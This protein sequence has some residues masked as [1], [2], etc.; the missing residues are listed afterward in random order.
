MSQWRIPRATTAER[1]TITPA[2]G[3]VIYDTDLDQL[4]L[5]DGATV[6]GFP[7]PA[8]GIPVTIAEGG[9]GQITAQAAIDALSAVSGATNEHVLTK[10][11]ATGN[12]IFKVAAGAGGGDNITVNSG[13]AT[14]ADF[15]DVTPAAGGGDLNV[16]WQ[17]SGASPTSIS[18]Y[19][20]VS[21]LEPLITL[22]NITEGDLKLND[23]DSAFI[24][25][26]QSTSTL[27][28]GRILTID[29][30]DAARTLTVA[31][32]ATISGTN[33]GDV[34]LAGALN[35][36][37]I[38]S[39][40]ITLGAVDLTTDITGDLPL[41]NL[42]QIAANTVLANPT[43][44]LDHAQA[45]AVGTNTV[46]GR[47]A[48]N[49]VAA[50]LATAQI[51][52]E[53]VTLAKMAHVSTARIL[54]RVTAATGDVESLT[55]TQ[56]TTLLDVFTDALQGLVPLSGGG[57]AN[58]LR[59]DGTWVAPGGSGDMV[60][61]SAQTNT[62]IKTFLDTTMKLRNVANTFDGY[63][64]NT[65]TAD[66]IYTLQNAA[67]T[68]AFTSDITVAADGSLP[69]DN[70]GLKIDDTGT[71]QLTIVPNENYTADRT[72]N[73][74]LGDADRTLTLDGTGFVGD[75]T[76]NAATVTTNAN[77]TGD[78]TS[79]G[80][81]ATIPVNSVD[82]TQVVEM[83]AYTIQ[84][85]NA[86]TTG[87]PAAVKISALTAGA[88]SS[89]DKIMLEEST[90]ELRQ[91]DWDDLPGGGA[92]DTVTVNGA[93][94]T[95]VD[96]DD[97]DPAAPAGDLNVKWQL[98]VAT[99]PDSVSAY[100][101]VS[102]LEPLITLT[103][104]ASGDLNL[105][106]TDSAFDLTVQ[107]T[108]TLTAGRILTLDV[109]DAARTLTIGGSTTLSGGTHSGTN[110]G[111][112]TI[113]GGRN[114]VT[115]SSQELTLGAVD[116]TAA[117]DI[118]GTL[119]PAN[120]GTGSTGTGTAG[121]VLVSNGT[122]WSA[123]NQELSKSVTIEAPT[124][125]EDITLFRANIGM[126]IDK[127]VIVFVGT[128]PSVTWTLKEDADRSAAGT[129]I[130]TVTST[131]TTTGEVITTITSPTVA[132]DDF[133]WLETSASSGTITNMSMTIF[134]HRTAGP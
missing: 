104:I 59:A 125:S 12:A 20:D 107:S 75:I 66:R 8:G 120:G 91:I 115:I 55:G 51:A 32:S 21:A 54:G 33:T 118:T 6:G 109:N 78:V 128:T 64:V 63:F 28:A 87:D 47:A 102:V 101:D 50:Q 10:D 4:Y 29:V 100:V 81:A 36:L 53:A 16:L 74:V 90:G 13:A 57:T 27:T 35:Y 111:D 19:V 49:I 93:A 73:I 117:A 110:T 94:T 124:A 25:T 97:A 38:S 83:A 108:S 76:G 46:L 112:V 40:E 105:N 60:L 122:I 121:Q 131:N 96:L 119:P 5:G 43:V 84:L 24:L 61:A 86:G 69:F 52:D 41:S 2:V 14:D 23:T 3:E 129:T 77:L 58:F 37:T 130:H 45:V 62:G 126:T 79:V 56:A 15:D 113:A 99:S 116:L 22:T 31:G 7:L 17:S 134:Y 42:A 44:S 71:D 114:Y 82:N 98:N 65:N 67:G 80:N 11:T 92:G 123:A 1:G 26:V 34:T 127:I 103:N 30:N 48:G 85:R 106:D 72:L 18:A 39:Q 89:G 133:V 95:D 88:G 132:A 70:T 68:I 9:T